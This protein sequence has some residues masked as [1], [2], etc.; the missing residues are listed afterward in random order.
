MSVKDRLSDHDVALVSICERYSQA[1]N[2]PERRALMSKIL[3][4]ALQRAEDNPKLSD[5]V[6]EALETALGLKE[7]K[8][9][10]TREEYAS[11]LSELLDESMITGID[12]F[13]VIPQTIT[14]YFK[15]DSQDAFNKA[16]N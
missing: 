8:R 3:N 7:E 14:E 4:M 9:R 6:G 11:L 1:K 15:E 5:K 2:G 13:E 16:V 10:L 12:R